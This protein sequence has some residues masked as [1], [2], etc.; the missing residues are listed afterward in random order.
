[1][2]IIFNG[3]N[4]DKVYF[5]GKYHNKIYH[6]STLVW[7]KG[8]SEEPPAETN[9]FVLNGGYDQTDVCLAKGGGSTYLYVTRIAPQYKYHTAIM[10]CQPNTTYTIEMYVQDWCRIASHSSI[11]S[12]NTYFNK[13]FSP[14][15]NETVGYNTTV[16]F[17]YTTGATDK[18]LF[19]FYWGE[20]ANSLN[21]DYLTTYNTIRIT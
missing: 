9:L 18:F 6:G 20:T 3:K 16:S 11:P 14:S 12:H 4:H 17:Q 15:Y 7:Q 10:P 5:N 8:T 13:S 1:M 19:I 21:G 2:S